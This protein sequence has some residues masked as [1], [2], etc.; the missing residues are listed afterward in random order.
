MAILRAGSRDQ[1]LT[2]LAGRNAETLHGR[3]GQL[4]SDGA[5]RLDSKRSIL[6]LRLP[7]TLDRGLAAQFYSAFSRSGARQRRNSDC[8]CAD[9]QP[10]FRNVEQAFVFVRIVVRDGSLSACLGTLCHDR[11]L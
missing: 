3:L 11:D 1:A 2:P 7:G 10:L 9:L 6:L 5:D 4:H 8:V